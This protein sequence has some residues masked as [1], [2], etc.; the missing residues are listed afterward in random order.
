MTEFSITWQ[1]QPGPQ[2]MLLKCPVFEVFYGGAR[3]GGKSDGVL[4][5]WASHADLYGQ[6]AIGL[7][8]RREYTQLKEL[9][10]RS[11]ILYGQIGAVWH[12]GDRYWEFPNGARLNFAHLDNDDD[13]EKYQGHSYTRIY[14]E[15]L[16]NFP[17]PDPIL[18]LMATLRSGYGV[19]CGFRATGNPGGPGHQWVKQRYIDPA[20]TG[21]KVLRTEYKNPFT[22][23]TTTRDR[24]F[25]PAKITD[26]V[27]NNT[28]EYV[29]QL[30]MAG[31]ERLVR[32]WLF[33]DWDVIIGA[34][35]DNWNPR[36]HVIKPIPISSRWL[37]FVAGDWGSAKPFCFGWYA[38]A[39]DAFPITRIDGSPALIPRGALIKYRELYGSMNHN[40][41]GVKL[42]AEQVAD[43]ILELESKEPHDM[44]GRSGIKYRVL[45]PACFANEGGPT[46]AE[47]FGVKKLLFQ[48]ANNQRTRRNNAIGGWDMLRQRLD[49]EDGRPMLYFF[50]TC[51]D[52][53]RTIPAL[54]HDDKNPEDVDTEAEDHAGDETRY[55][56]MSRPWVK[57]VH[58][59]E[60]PAMTEADEHG[61]VRIDLDRLFKQ[62]EQLKRRPVRSARI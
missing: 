60:M 45:D 54:Q 52:S 40:N 23:V 17:S 55:A 3:G 14:V 19:P 9:L 59:A 46:I 41:V 12:K 22:N 48:S 50:D 38:V 13:A 21:F 1:P 32:A 31:T 56:V 26:N 39:G 33:G 62:N 27:Y 30:Q 29:A 43:R 8:V 2:T 16:G 49:G 10:E 35:F 36:K 51:I 42:T 44:D 24:T 53:I 25:I 4:G 57:T 7:V 11:K 61:N 58:P 6:H 47:R 15:E 34:Y 18:K 28:P 20:P 5:E 37:R